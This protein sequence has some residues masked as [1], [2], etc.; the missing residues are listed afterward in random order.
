[1]PGNLAFLGPGV[2]WQQTSQTSPR[3]K[4]TPQTESELEPWIRLAS[5]TLSTHCSS[6]AGAQLYIKYIDTP[7]CPCGMVFHFKLDSAGSSACRKALKAH[8]SKH[9]GVHF[10][11]LSASKSSQGQHIRYLNQRYPGAAIIPFERWAVPLTYRGVSPFR[12]DSS[13]TAF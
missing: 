4:H 2:Y 11:D 6:Y 1:M 10:W 12:P 8:M 7:V 5:G 9:E 3:Q 13:P